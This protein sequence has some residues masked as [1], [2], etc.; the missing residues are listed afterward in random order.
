MFEIELDLKLK[1]V[2]LEKK[3]TKIGVNIIK[4]EVNYWFWSELI[5][6]KMKLDLIFKTNF[7]LS[8][9]HCET[10]SLNI[11]PHLQQPLIMPS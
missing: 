2:F 6:N 5:K 7:N 3:K 9:S 8:S 10:K 1:Y 4:L 11:A